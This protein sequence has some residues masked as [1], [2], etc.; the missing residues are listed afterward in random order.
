MGGL[1]LSFVVMLLVGLVCNF[2]MKLVID[3]KAHLLHK[4]ESVTTFPD[5]GSAIYGRWFGGLIEFA[6]TTAQMGFC[7]AY[8]IFIGENMSSVLGGI[9]MYAWMMSVVPFLVL[10]SWITNIKYLAW[11]SL[12]ANVTLFLGICYVFLYIV[13]DFEIGRGVRAVN[14][15]Q[16][17]ILYGIAAYAFEGINLTIPIQSSMSRPADYPFIL[18]VSMFIT[19]VLYVGLALLGYA[20]YGNRTESIITLNL[21]EDIPT[22]IMIILMAIAMFFTFPVQL[23]PVSEMVD[24]W[25]HLKRGTSSLVIKRRLVRLVLVL[26]CLGFAMGVPDFGLFLA[27]I[28]G[29]SNSLVQFVFPSLMY[30]RLY[31]GSLRWQEI[32]LFTSIGILGT[33]GLI[34]STTYSIIEIGN[35]LSSKRTVGGQT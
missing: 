23:F 26:I 27:L 12:I 2:T 30:L 31:R 33:A 16:F 28:G 17:P 19:G 5:C 6:V 11:P 13:V 1:V 18:D 9:T 8:L 4:G 15:S 24:E 3:M 25:L 29:F 10:L 20:R 14:W 32:L 22:M 7:C 35:S 34:L 21:P